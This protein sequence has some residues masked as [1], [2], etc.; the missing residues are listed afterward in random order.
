MFKRIRTYQYIDARILV[1][2][3]SIVCAATG[4]LSALDGDLVLYSGFS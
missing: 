1:T 4:V 2:F 3:L